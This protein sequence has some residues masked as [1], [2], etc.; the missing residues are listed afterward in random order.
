M[1]WPRPMAPHLV[2]KEPLRLHKNQ[3]R[4]FTINES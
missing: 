2:H 1:N 4:S 3:V